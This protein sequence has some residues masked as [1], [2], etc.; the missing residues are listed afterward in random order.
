M[1]PAPVE[2]L[3]VRQQRIPVTGIEPETGHS[4][5]ICNAERLQTTE[6]GVMAREAVSIQTTSSSGLHT[7]WFG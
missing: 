3:P 5:P 1:Q 7:L 6:P 2:G 4:Y